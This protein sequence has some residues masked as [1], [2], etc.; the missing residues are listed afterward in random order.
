VS[1]DDHARLGE[2]ADELA[3]FIGNKAFMRMEDGH[4][5]ALRITT[6][7]QFL[8]NA[9]ELRPGTCRELEEGSPEC[10]GEK[11]TKGER[12]GEALLTLRRSRHHGAP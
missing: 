12:P 5:I 10:E 9:Y 3:H 11:A 2:R 1:G 4:C 7:G 6:D 8:C